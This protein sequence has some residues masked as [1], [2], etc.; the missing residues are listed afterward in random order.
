MAGSNET[1]MGP[2]H[3]TLGQAQEHVD[4]K[5]NA[6][7][8]ESKRQLARGCLQETPVTDQTTFMPKKETIFYVDTDAMREAGA[9]A[10]A[11]NIDAQKATMLDARASANKAFDAALSA[12][13]Q[14]TADKAVKVLNHA[15]EVI[16]QR[17]FNDYHVHADHS[18]RGIASQSEL[19]TSWV[20]TVL[21]A[22]LT[23]GSFKREIEARE[24]NGFPVVCE[25][26][27]L[28]K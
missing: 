23:D 2:G 12:V 8:T 18:N 28:V 4:D 22:Q 17:N 13:D 3:I 16:Y 27:S 11:K 14:D 6:V 19:E 21:A 25:D 10:Q 20:K 5:I 26:N 9:D 15:K 7:L 24:A 1:V